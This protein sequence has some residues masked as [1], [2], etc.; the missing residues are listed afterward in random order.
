MG[1]ARHSVS[2][3]IVGASGQVGHHLALAA[4]RR[5]LP[6]GG[7]FHANPRPG[8]EALDVRD[9]AAVARVVGAA[10]PAYLMVPAAA[11]HVER[12][13]LEAQRTYGVNVVGTSHLVNAANAVGAV[14]VYFSSDYVF[15]GHAGP[16]DEFAPTNP[17]SQ[18]GAQKLSAEH[19][20]MQ[21]AHEA[22]IVRT[23]VVYGLEPQGKNFIY[24]LLA[25]LR[26]G[27]EIAVPM[28]QISTPTYA[29]ALA[30]AVF[31]LLAAG[32]RGIINVAGRDL[33][34]RE[35]FA[36]VAASAFGEDPSLVRPVLTS[37]LGQAAPRPLRAGL[38]SEPAERRLG[39]ELPGCTEGL[40]R[41]T[42]EGLL[43]MF[44]PNPIAKLSPRNEIRAARHAQ[45]SSEAH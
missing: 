45:R 41:L 7:T 31:D 43:E 33:V 22:L 2:V 20:I 40:R 10:R 23:T 30:D 44:D 6:W 8:L 32:V 25:A 42:S 39:W 36:R 28:D 17:I 29:P 26:K 27:E 14:V 11:A 19:L 3:L 24:R 18:Y 5:G 15:D 37:E 21:R 1:S 13:E 16:Y 4:E 38:R 35:E 12:C 9:A 34:T